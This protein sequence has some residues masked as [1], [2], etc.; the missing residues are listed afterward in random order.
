MTRDA[1]HIPKLTQDPLRQISGLTGPTLDPPRVQCNIIKSHDIP[2]IL[3]GTVCDVVGQDP[4]KLQPRSLIIRLPLRRINVFASSGK[5]PRVL[6]LLHTTDA[7]KMVIDPGL[8][9]LVKYSV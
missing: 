8:Q 7:L 1:L 5:F 2:V 6:L 3:T 9:K 4:I